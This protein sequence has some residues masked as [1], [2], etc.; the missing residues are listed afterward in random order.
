MKIARFFVKLG[1]LLSAGIAIPISAIAQDWEPINNPDELRQ[2]LNGK[3]LDGEDFADYYRADGAMGYFNK[4]YSTTVI[5]KW[6]VGENGE[7]CMYIFVK[8]DKLV[9]CQ[10]VERSAVDSDLIRL[11]ISG[12][13]YSVQARLTN[14]P[15]QDLVD[16]VTKTAG[17]SN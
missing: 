15:L 17:P 1:L 3:G 11:T 5:R 14:T 8:P 4:Q 13:G 9:S 7:I 6:V 2:L 12:R 10:T 16:A